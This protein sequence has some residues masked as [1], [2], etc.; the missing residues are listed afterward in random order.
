L[1]DPHEKLKSYLRL[2]IAIL[3]AV[4]AVITFVF[5]ALVNL[6]I[7]LIWKEVSIVLGVVTRLFT[8]LVCIIG[9]LLVVLLVMLFG[10][11]NAIFSELI[12]EFRKT[13][14][15][16]YRQAH[17]IVV[18]AF[19]SL[20]TCGSLGLNAPLADACGGLGMLAAGKLK[21]DEQKTRTMGFGGLSAMLGDF[22][23]NPFGGVLLGLGS[24]QG[25]ATGASP[26]FR[27]L[28]PSLLASAVATVVFVGLTGNFIN[29]LTFVQVETAPVIVVAVLISALLV[30]LLEMRETRQAPALA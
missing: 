28:F 3:V 8:F 20:I 10:D 6:L 16:G 23:T 15:F 2:L 9:D 22:I 24:A 13:G 18:T 11:H 7:D 30:A 1:I 19:I 17:G 27:A 5:I 29:T 25:G 26:N 4:S 12:R 14:R 21:L